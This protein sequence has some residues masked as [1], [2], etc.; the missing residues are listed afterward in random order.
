V[1]AQVS[2]RWGDRQTDYL[3]E[4]CG[5]TAQLDFSMVFGVILTVQ[6]LDRWVDLIDLRFTPITF[7][8]RDA[9]SSLL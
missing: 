4:I 1:R 9:M 5:D 7:L 8:P 2:Y 3:Y 6:L